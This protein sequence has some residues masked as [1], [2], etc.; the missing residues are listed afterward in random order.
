[1]QNYQNQVIHAQAAND[2]QEKQ[3]M[4]EQQQKIERWHA[5]QRKRIRAEIAAKHEKKTHPV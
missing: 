5:G 3:H 4:S 2:R 1:M